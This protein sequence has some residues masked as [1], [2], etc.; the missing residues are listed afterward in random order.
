MVRTGR[1]GRKEKSEEEQLNQTVKT[2]LT[3]ADLKGLQQHF[4]RHTVGQKISFAEYVRQLLLART[5]RK[6][7]SDDR[8]TLLAIQ[9]ELAEIGSRLNLIVGDTGQQDT[10]FLTRGLFV[11][12]TEEGLERLMV[13][14]NI[15]RI[16]AIIKQ[17]S[18]WLYDCSPEKI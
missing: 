13:K 3:K 16:E 5:D 2:T 12:E 17:I 11:N 8:L 1:G 6:N 4:S 18:K 7:G 10:V 9:L 15:D 14:Q